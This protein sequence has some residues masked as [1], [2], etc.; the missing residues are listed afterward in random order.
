MSTC[1]RYKIYNIKKKKETRKDRSGVYRSV[2]IPPFVGTRHEDETM[3]IMTSEWNMAAVLL[4]VDDGMSAGLPVG[5]LI[6][7]N[8]F[9]SEFQHL[10]LLSCAP[11]MEWNFEVATCDI[12]INHG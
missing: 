9:H 10:G 8:S 11:S 7:V 2:W 4:W 6:A 3:I 5:F 1:L 12:S